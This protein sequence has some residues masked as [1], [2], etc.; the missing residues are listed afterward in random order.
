MAGD[1]K[2]VGTKQR[3]YACVFRW[4]RKAASGGDFI[5]V[6]QRLLLFRTESVGSQRP[7]RP[8]LLPGSNEFASSYER[9]ARGNSPSQCR[10]AVCPLVHER[11]GELAVPGI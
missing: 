9:C 8:F 5:L 11:G 1:G 7:H 3:P 10:P 2:I 6:C 4:H